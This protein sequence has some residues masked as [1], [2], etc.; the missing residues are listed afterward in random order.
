MIRIFFWLILLAN[1]ALFAFMRWG[2]AWLRNDAGMQVQ[3]PLNADKIKLLGFTAAK[4]GAASA[5]ASSTPPAP[6]A[7]APPQPAPAAVPAPLAPP[8]TQAACLEWG[9]FSGVDLTHA[10]ADLAGLKLGNRLTQREVEHAIGYWVYIPPLKTRAEVNDKI[11]QLKKLGVKEYFIVQEKGK[12]QNTISLGV[13]K[14]EGVAHRFLDSLKAKGLRSAVIGERQTRLKFTVFVLK[15]PV[16]DT[17]SKLAE[18]QKDFTDIG[19]KAVP[20]D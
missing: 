15:N 11:A 5:A 6:Q 14:A 9:E 10:S 19:M 4:T 20:C 7:S 17:L 8:S 1:L 18:W 13:F 3:Q 2:D 16:A 12:W